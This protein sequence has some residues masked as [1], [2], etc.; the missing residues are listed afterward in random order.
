MPR[1]SAHPTPSVDRLLAII[2]L[3]GEIAASRA[4]LDSVMRVV[5]DRAASL[6]GAAGAVIELV[7]G[8]E[9]VY[10]TA[11]GSLAASLRLRL[12]RAASLSGR[13]VEERAILRADDTATDAR[14]DREACRRVGA[15]SMICVP[16]FHDGLVVGVL[17][18]VSTRAR[19]FRDDD[20]ATLGMLATI[21]AASMHHAAALEAARHDS[22]HDAL[23]GLLNR[24]AFDE[25]LPQELERRRRYPQPLSLVLLDLD[26][27]KGINDDLGHAA[28]DDCLRCVGRI[29]THAIRS[30]DGAFRLGGDEFAVLMPSTGVDS[31]QLAADRFARD[32]VEAALCAGR[33]G[34]SVGVAEALE[35]ES[36]DALLAR[37]DASLYEAK[38]CRR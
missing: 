9:M 24:R 19:A 37:A 25:R 29:L 18:V 15:A 28:G 1:P 31:A 7:E 16:L 17:K 10:R 14:V 36:A 27:F 12:Q 3:Q 13:C 23:T 34:V 20:V 8:D 32:V 35:G 2:A 30:C 11:S 4:D 33:L 6:T 26:G 5:V 22:T 21:I 38:R